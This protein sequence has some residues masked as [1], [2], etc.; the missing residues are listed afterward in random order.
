MNE[1]ALVVLEQ[2]D[3]NI[4]SVR[5]GRGSFLVETDKGLKRF[6]EYQGTKGRLR[7]QNR[8]LSHLREEGFAG[9]DMVMENREGE[10]LSLDK[11]ETA[12]IVKDWYEGRECDVNSLPD[13]LLAIR[14]LAALHKRMRLERG[15][16][17]G[18]TDV[19]LLEELERKGRELRKVRKFIR[20][21]HGKNEFEQQ[22]LDWY[23]M[24]EEEAERVVEE[25]RT[26]GGSSLFEE[27]L[28][29]GCIVHGDFNQHHILFLKR[30]E[31]V[32][33]FG[34]CRY[35]VQVG[36]FCQFL[37][38]V[39]E[40]RDWDLEF[41]REMLKEYAKIRP[42]SDQERLELRLR[43]WYPE[44][45]WKLANHYYAS[46]KAWLPKKTTEKLFLLKEQQKFKAEFLKMLE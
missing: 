16:D 24:F 42:L 37:R 2:Y 35:G 4:L 1:K 32:T 6:E 28:R 29:N 17:E 5:R 45:F 9:V 34:R 21:R 33:E 41:G 3:L 13:V 36:D 11:D 19:P 38:K 30:G 25:L 7:F 10:L 12:Y 40:K 22:F 46:N 15:E 8:V 23:G 27:S 20:A 39:L 14:T 18:Y 31:A 26:K 43:L 44:K